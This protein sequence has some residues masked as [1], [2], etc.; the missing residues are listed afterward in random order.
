[1]Y[2]MISLTSSL[3]FKN[4]H[5]IYIY[6]VYRT[7][8]YFRSRRVGASPFEIFEVIVKG[9]FPS[10]CRPSVSNCRPNSQLYNSLS[11]SLFGESIRK[12]CRYA[13]SILFGSTSIVC[14]GIQPIVYNFRCVLNFGYCYLRL[15]LV[16]VYFS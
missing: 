13:A 2:I 8:Q 16:R 6:I 15:V 4:I 7:V 12:V 9:V 11:S 14:D 5:K 1:M 10:D 3:S